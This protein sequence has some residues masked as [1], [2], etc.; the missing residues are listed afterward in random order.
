MHIE[1]RRLR[2]DR[3][4]GIVAATLRSNGKLGVKI[5]IVVAMVRRVPTQGADRKIERV[6]REIADEDRWRRR[7]AADEVRHLDRLLRAEELGAL[8]VDDDQAR[9]IAALA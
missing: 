1:R 5:R 4:L 7:P 3:S 6:E 9:R 8:D 2:L